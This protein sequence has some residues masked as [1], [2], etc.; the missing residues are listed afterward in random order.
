MSACTLS[1]RTLLQ[2]ESEDDADGLFGDR[3]INA[4]IRDKTRDKFVHGPTRY[5]LTALTAD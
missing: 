3:L 4:D 5:A 2:Q 1:G